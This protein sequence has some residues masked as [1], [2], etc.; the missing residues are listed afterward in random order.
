MTDSNLIASP[1]PKPRTIRHARSNTC[2]ARI[3]YVIPGQSRLIPRCWS[4]SLQ[5]VLIE[6]DSDHDQRADCDRYRADKRQLF[7][8]ADDDRPDAE[9]SLHMREAPACH[10]HSD[11]S[12]WPPA[13][14]VSLFS[15]RQSPAKVN[16][17]C[18]PGSR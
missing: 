6:R 8:H 7:Q 16:S 14:A 4:P 18:I 5:P 10:T 12:V 3:L 15:A 17:G 11:I 9:S 1:K 2:K 13:A